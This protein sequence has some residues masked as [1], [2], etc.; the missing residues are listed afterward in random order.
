[1][2]KTLDRVIEKRKLSDQSSSAESAN[3]PELHRVRS[4]SIPRS[5]PSPHCDIYNHKC[6]ICTHIKHQN[7]VKKF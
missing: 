3:E 7:V 6:V 4:Q 5:P 1:M 2:R